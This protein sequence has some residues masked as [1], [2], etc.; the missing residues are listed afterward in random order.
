MKWT[1]FL[2]ALLCMLV[3]LACTHKT[4]N[5][6][7]ATTKIDSTAL[8]IQT[9]RNTRTLSKTKRLE[10]L[11]QAAKRIDGYANNTGKIEALSRLSLAYK[12]I[13]DSL[14]FRA[15]NLQFMQLAKKLNELRPQVEAHWD[16]ATFYRNTYPD[17]AFLHYQEAYALAQKTDLPVSAK[18]YPGNILVDMANLK[19][20]NK[21]HIG[22]EKDIVNAINFYNDNGMHDL[23][24]GAYNR[25]AII[26]NGM[27]KYDKALEYHSKAKEYISFSKKRNQYRQ[28]TEN[29]NNLAATNLRKG[30]YTKAISLYTSLLQTD[31]LFQKYSYSYAK[32]LSGLAYAK[33]KNGATNYKELSQEFLSSNAIL[34]SLNNHAD[35]ARN[36]E[37]YAELLHQAGNSPLA[38]RNAKIAKHIAEESFNNDRLLSSLKLLTDLDTINSK[39]YAQEYY[40][41]NDKLQAQERSI[42]DKFA[43]IELETDEAIE[44]NIALAKERKKLIWIGIAIVLL[45]LGAFIIIMQRNS[46]Q[47]LRFKQKQQE[48][49]EEIVNLMQLQQ[50]KFQE[51]KQ[52][53]QKRISEEI[54]DGLLGQMLGIRLIL[55]GL[56]KR[57]DEASV[58]QR[59][60]IIEKFR[61]V[62][63]E[64]R[65]ISHELSDTAY[66]KIN[67]YSI[68]IKDLVDTVGLS[69]KI[70]MKFDY[71]DTF[72]WDTL[73]GTIKTNTY[74]ILQE[75]LQNAVKHAKCKNITVALNKTDSAIQ[76]KVVDDGA[77]FNVK[78]GK[79]GIGHKNI[80][81]RVE[82]IGANLKINCILGKGT[83]ISVDVPLQTTSEK[84]ELN[85]TLI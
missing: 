39:Q 71:T 35:K 11:T 21:D 81:S 25:L 3:Q 5:N 53:E 78:K 6:E 30:E 29:L 82:K 19:D 4:K 10:I 34:D 85:K 49:D 23:M 73:N 63:E 77:G 9:A 36:Y 40:K 37:Y 44:K 80:T 84:T 60:E 2:L 58:K 54:H 46:N 45:G 14:A 50:T 33:F 59:A 57:S 47:K 12:S 68:T 48:S 13:G 61:D 20:T 83:T 64:M 28:T 79:K 56:N 8:L 24:Y 70:N 74:R 32:A 62:E 43:R 55:S 18:S 67:S 15:K 69:S 27:G 75:S 52:L 31:S 26:Q 16:L 51:G 42:Q 38:I 22:A 65:T 7:T 41:L 72:D 1:T 17:S 66:Q 76:L